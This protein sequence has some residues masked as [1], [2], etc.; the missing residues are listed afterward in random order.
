MDKTTELLIHELV[1]KSLEGTIVESEMHQLNQLV[2]GDPQAAAY[3][4]SCVRLHFAFSKTGPLLR[5]HSQPCA[6]DGVHVLQAFAE[7]EMTAPGVEIPKIPIEGHPGPT[8]G[9][10]Q[11]R[12]AKISKTPLMTVL[13]SCA[14]LL[15]VLIY[16]YIKP[17]PME[18]ATLTDAVDAQCLNTNIMLL[19][20][21]RLQTAQPPVMLTGGIVK[22]LYDNDVE[23]LIEAPAEYQIE[24]SGAIR[25]NYGRLFARV[26]EAGKG[27]SVFTRNTKI[28]DLGTEFGVYADPLNKTELHVFKGKTTATVTVNNT[29]Q[30]I[31]VIG[32]QAREIN[33]D[34]L[35]REIHL[36]K[37]GF[38]R[39]IDSKT[40]LVW[41]GQKLDLADVV[42]KGNGLGTGSSD[43]RLNYEKGY[44]TEIRWGHTSLFETYLPIEDSPFIDGIF[45]PNGRTIISSRGDVFEGFP[46][47]NGVYCAD[48][49]ANPKPGAFV[50]DGQPRTIQF[51]GQEYSE[52]GKSCIVMQ[53][54]NHGV[55]FDL[56][57]IRKCY[58]LKIDRFESQ[59]G[60]VDFDE[61]RCNANFYVLVDGQLRYS[62]LGYTQKGI[63]NRVL[64]NLKDT[65]RF[66]T[67]A[68]SE[69]VDQIDYMAN[70]TL[71]ENWCVFAEPVLVMESD[72]SGF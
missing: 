30:T 29:V 39:A 42:R 33:A 12:A 41:R 11:A 3:Y 19:P 65:D 64:V 13:I 18:V 25:L 1:N 55:T 38:V 46:F 4:V 61:K 15:M 62:L 23:V 31:G 5:E 60:L 16:I 69:N 35:A 6:L 53:N 8:A 57:A 32:G 22:L 34:G 10:E 21:A 72:D 50:I 52:L 70:S 43:K 58:H 36:K 20:G 68:T 51:G 40:D 49:I 28:V 44:T 71:H 45:I 37:E 59:V 63:L 66:L 2:A 56:D 67:L 14:A 9:I 48:L 54:S 24:S 7:Y 27:F 47:T 17:V 26:S